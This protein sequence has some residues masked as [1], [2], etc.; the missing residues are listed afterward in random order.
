MVPQTKGEKLFAA[1][2]NTLPYETPNINN[3]DFDNVKTKSNDNIS[4]NTGNF[5]GVYTGIKN[6]ISSQVW[7]KLEVLMYAKNRFLSL[8]GYK[9]ANYYVNNSYKPRII[10]TW[11]QGE[12]I[13]SEILK[14]KA[15][16]DTAESAKA[17]A[18][19]AAAEKAILEVANNIIKDESSYKTNPAKSV[20][21][22]MF[23]TSINADGTS[24][25]NKNTLYSIGGIIVT[26]IVGIWYFNRNKKQNN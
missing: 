2:E 13:S 6:V 19:K 23:A 1:K 10:F 7:Y 22:S 9:W 11:F 4:W 21:G 3:P 17:L 18:E 14:T 8:N 5:I 24:T 25:L 12:D 16:N 15:E 26:G 20:L